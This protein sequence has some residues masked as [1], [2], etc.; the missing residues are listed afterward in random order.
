MR[1]QSQVA[2]FL[3]ERKTMFFDGASLAIVLPGYVLVAGV[4]AVIGSPF[5]HLALGTDHMVS[6]VLKAPSSHH[7]RFLPGMDGD[8]GRDAPF[9]QEQSQPARIVSGVS[10]QRDWRQGEVFK[11]LGQ[12]LPF[13]LGSVSDSPGKDETARSTMALSW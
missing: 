4:A 1:G 2:A 6:P 11:Q 8:I 12:G 3:M 5:Q 9:L 10:R 7:V 13:P